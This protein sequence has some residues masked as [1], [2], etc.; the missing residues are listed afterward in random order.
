MTK[1]LQRVNELLR[2]EISQ[3]LLRQF[4]FRDV[5]VTIT[6]V[7][8]SIDLRQAKIKISIMPLEKSQQI[9]R[10]LEKNIFSLQ[11][12]LNKKLIMRPVPKIR[13]EI[14]KSAIDAQR[15]EEL[16]QKIHEEK[17]SHQSCS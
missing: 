15:V 3:L 5:F 17:D 8:T 14:D 11:Q 1:R 12:L 6:R 7:E 9:L 13:F 16:L 2:R 4:G 10:I